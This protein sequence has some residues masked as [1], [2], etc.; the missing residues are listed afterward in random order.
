VNAGH[1]GKP[2]KTRR[3]PGK[4]LPEAEAED[5]EKKERKRSW[6]GSPP[7]LPDP[8]R[9]AAAIIVSSLFAQSK[10][11]LARSGTVRK[12]FLP[13]NSHHTCSPKCKEHLFLAFFPTTLFQTCP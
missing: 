6:K 7:R 2:R 4:T 8:R 13:L 10:L 5:E 1:V 9:L 12:R 11:P 3:M